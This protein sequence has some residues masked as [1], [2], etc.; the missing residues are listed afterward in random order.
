MFV[1]LFFLAQCFCG[2][3]Q[4]KYPLWLQDNC[5]NMDTLTNTDDKQPLQEFDKLTTKAEPQDLIDLNGYNSDDNYQCFKTIRNKNAAAQDTKDLIS[6][7]GCTSAEVYKGP[8]H[9]SVRLQPGSNNILL[10]NAAQFSTP[11]LYK[12]RHCNGDASEPSVHAAKS[13]TSSLSS[14]YS[15][16]KLSTETEI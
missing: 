15:E 3:R 10:D 13:R 11:V 8:R 9:C 4:K 7:D 14:N 1:L 2:I 12:R 6:F 16:R 5:R